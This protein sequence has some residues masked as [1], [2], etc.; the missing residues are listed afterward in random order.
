MFTNFDKV[1]FS[2]LK[3]IFSEIIRVNFPK[4]RMMQLIG[5]SIVITGD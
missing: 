1:D 3:T 4:L 2:I 5:K